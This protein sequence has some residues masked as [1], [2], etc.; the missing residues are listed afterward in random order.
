MPPDPA[1]GT[2]L[3]WESI[4]QGDHLHSPLLTRMRREGTGRSLNDKIALFRTPAARKG[5][6]LIVLKRIEKYTT[7]LARNCDVRNSTEI[8]PSDLLPWDASILSCVTSFKAAP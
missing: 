4:T 7:L 1:I 6:H 8:D 2:V 3:I 5:P